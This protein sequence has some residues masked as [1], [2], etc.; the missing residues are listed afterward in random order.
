MPE[1]DSEDSEVF[2]DIPRHGIRIEDIG[3]MSSS[4]DSWDGRVI[5]S[6]YFRYH[7]SPDLVS[8]RP[9]KT[10]D[11]TTLLRAISEDEY[12][13]LIDSDGETIGNDDDGDIFT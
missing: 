2:I 5:P 8:P 3:S 13:R 1:S 9:I 6:P 10:Y 12:P 7:S 11:F 4:P